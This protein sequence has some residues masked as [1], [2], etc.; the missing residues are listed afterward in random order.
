MD[1]LAS[2][3]LAAVAL[4]AAFQV[5]RMIWE[6]QVR[7]EWNFTRA[8]MAAA[9]VLFVFLFSDWNIVAGTGLDLGSAAL[10]KVLTGLGLARAT[11]W[12]HNV[13]MRTGKRD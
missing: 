7:A 8:L 2:L 10:G 11:Q 13:Y 3:I 5:L 12:V 9:A 1:G 6:P 4:E